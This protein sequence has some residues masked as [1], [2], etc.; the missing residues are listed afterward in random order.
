MP[1]PR[2]TAQDMLDRVRDLLA[3]LV[4]RRGFTPAD[5][6][7]V[8]VIARRDLT[9]E[10]ESAVVIATREDDVASVVGLIETAD[11]PEV[12]LVVRRDARALRRTT[13]WAHISAYARRRGLTLGVVATRRDVRTFARQNGLRA[14]S[15][16]RS[17]YPSRHSFRLGDREVTL[18]AVPWARLVRAGLAG[19]IL[20]AGIVVACAV[21]PSATV[22]I[23]PAAEPISA[24]GSARPNALIA[25]SD[26][27][28]GV[29]QADNLRR[30]L[31]IP[32]TSDATGE[33]EVGDQPAELDLR[34]TNEGASVVEVPAGTIVSDEDGVRFATAEGVDVPAAGEVDVQAIAVEPGTRGNV[35][36]GT[37]TLVEGLPPSISVTNLTPGRGG[38][39][40][41]AAAAAQ[42]D[43]DRIAAVAD[44]VLLRLARSIIED[45]VDSGTLLGSTVTI[46]IFS[47]LPMQE[48]GEA[49]DFVIVDYVVTTSALV[50]PEDVAVSFGEQLL[51]SQLPPGM[52]LIPGSVTAE[53]I[54]SELRG[55]PV[56]VS[57]TGHATALGPIEAAA[58]TL[59][60]RRVGDAR[61]YLEES[62]D[63]LEP[64]KIVVRPTF[65]PWTSL[66]RRGSRIEVVI[67]GPTSATTSDASTSDGGG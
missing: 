41:P 3:R 58:Q 60:G 13:A 15:S 21:V 17:L 36:A 31:H 67:A 30:Q 16:I 25:A 19:A 56:T 5:A 65:L 33:T 14:A 44:A 45:E 57:A 39:D 50:I 34:L 7:D 27:A 26:V 51:R 52:A 53:V 9:S 61:A 64:P 42:E 49:S 11:A 20:A 28:S 43:F 40:R 12:I 24:V 18:P 63:L 2:G 35:D 38:T 23:V 22:T 54:A 62:L 55:D 46:A 6:D 66:P 47:M 1:D 10:S 59:A 29:I 37:V 32:V 4:G 8:E 48:V